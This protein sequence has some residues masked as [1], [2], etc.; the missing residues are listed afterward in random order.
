MEAPQHSFDDPELRGATFAR[1][2]WGLMAW[3]GARAIVFRA[4]D[5][6]GNSTAVRF[7]LNRDPEAGTRYETLARH[8]SAAIRSRRS[9]GHPGSPTA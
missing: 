5:S 4:V 8:L 6:A 7:L 2:S 9:P 1:G 3:S